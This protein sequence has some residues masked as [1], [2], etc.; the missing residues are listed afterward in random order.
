MKY[1]TR[2]GDVTKFG[3]KNADFLCYAFKAWI[4]INQKR[5]ARHVIKMGNKDLILIMI[6]KFVSN[7]RQ[8]DGFL[9]FSPPIKLTATI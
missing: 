4:W 9:R 5:P 1:V 2:D 8:A 3:I 7:L 6:M